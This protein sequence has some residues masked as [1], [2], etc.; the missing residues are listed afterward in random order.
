[1]ILT[2]LN[3]FIQFFIFINIKRFFAL[4]LSPVLV[5]VVRCDL[6]L[7]CVNFEGAEEEKEKKKN[8]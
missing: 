4:K 5:S 8:I 3:F 6:L 1:M 2:G 7:A